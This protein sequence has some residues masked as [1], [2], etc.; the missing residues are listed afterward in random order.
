MNNPK[1]VYL[2]AGGRCSSNKNIFKAVFKEISKPNPLIAYVGA[3]NN[4]DKRFYRFMGDEITKAGNCTLNHALIASPKADLDKAQ[5]ILQRADAVFISGGDVDAG[6]QVLESGNILG[7]FRA[8]YQEGKVFFGTSAG[9]IMLAKEWVRWNDP[10]DASTAELFP[11]LNIAPVICDTHAEEDDWEE[12]KTALQFKEKN[13]IGYGIPSGACLKVYPDGHIVA[14]GGA[15]AQYVK[16]G[17]K[18][19]KLDDLLPS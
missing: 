16:R 14:L 4:D 15:V 2:L 19:I 12:L 13:S 10:D 18:I 6:M 1:P 3:A 5:D 17:Q 8:L 7:L 9:S 11:C